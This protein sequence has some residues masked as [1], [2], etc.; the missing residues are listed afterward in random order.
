[1]AILNPQRGRCYVVMHDYLTRGPRAA[2][3]EKSTAFIQF[4][5][6]EIDSLTC[7]K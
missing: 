4:A 6:G 1:M 7:K 5:K 3:L 2:M